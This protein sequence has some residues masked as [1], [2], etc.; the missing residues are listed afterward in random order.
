M[1]AR[2]MPAHDSFEECARRSVDW[3]RDERVAPLVEA[4]SQLERHPVRFVH[5]GL[6]VIPARRWLARFPKES[7]LFLKSED[8]FEDPQ[9]VTDGVL[10]YLGLDPHPLK[11]ASARKKGRYSSALTP[12]AVRLLGEFYRPYN[13][14]LYE[15]LG[16]DFGWEAETERLR[17]EIGQA[18]SDS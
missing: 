16:R 5:R 13:E 14:Q 8:L 9:R 12:A 7:I 11:D 10:R 4:V 1:F 3:I 18:A 17:S 2:D 6:Y 15:L